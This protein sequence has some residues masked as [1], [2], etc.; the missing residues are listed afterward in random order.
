VTERTTTKREAR[1]NSPEWKAADA[2]LDD[3]TALLANASKYRDSLLADEKAAES[4]LKKQEACVE[5]VQKQLEEIK[6]PQKSD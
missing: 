3:A 1:L 5:T 6:S 4:R 2:A